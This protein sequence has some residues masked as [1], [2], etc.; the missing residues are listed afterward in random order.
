MSCRVIFVT[1]PPGIGKTTLVMRVAEYVKSR[2]YGVGGIVTEELREGGVRVGFRMMD[3]HT[4]ATG[5]LSHINLR[6]GPRLGRYVVN[7]KDLESMGVKALMYGLEEREVRLLVLDEIGPMELHSRRFISAA[8][9]AA[10][11]G[12]PFLGTVQLKLSSRVGEIL[13]LDE[14]P[15]VVGL[16]RENRVRQTKLISD[17]ILKTIEEESLKPNL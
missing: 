1:G 8:T 2:G 10:R 15:E 12:K 6:E 17:R 5:V 9:Q 3:L 14:T 16:T 11:C 7:I 4:G 13:G